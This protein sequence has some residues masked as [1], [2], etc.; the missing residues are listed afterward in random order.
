ME[1]EEVFQLAIEAFRRSYD[2]RKPYLARQA[3]YRRV[4][5]IL[6]PSDYDRV[7]RFKRSLDELEQL[8]KANDGGEK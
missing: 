5:G 7:L 2:P 1:M 8:L 3:A 4:V 6:D